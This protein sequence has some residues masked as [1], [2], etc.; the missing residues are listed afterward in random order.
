MAENKTIKVSFA[1]EPKGLQDARN[2]IRALTSDIKQL[3]EQM[4]RAG[5]GFGGL[6]GGVS[7]KTGSI[8]PQKE[9]IRLPNVGSALAG[10]ITKDAQALGQVSRAGTQAIDSLTR[11][12]KSNFSGQIQDIERLKRELSSL[13]KAYAKIQG[14]AG[15]G[16][17]PSVQS[18]ARSAMVSKE[19]QMT[20][21]QAQ[22][23]GHMAAREG[24]NAHFD[25]ARRW[26]SGAA[27]GP[28]AQTEAANARAAAGGGS[29][30]GR[31]FFGGVMQGTGLGG[32]GALLGFAGPAAAG[33]AVAALAKQGIEAYATRHT[34]NAANAVSIGMEPGRLGARIGSSL[35]G[36]GMSIR[37]GSLSTSVAYDAM[38]SQLGSRNDFA[39]ARERMYQDE[40]NMTG[41]GVVTG[42]VSNTLAD[43]AQFVANG[44]SAKGGFDKDARQLALQ[45]SRRGQVAEI[46][47]EQAEMIRNRVASNPLESFFYDQVYNNASSHRSWANAGG[48]GMGV[49]RDKSGKAIDTKMGRFETRALRAGFEAG[50]LAGGMGQLG[51]IAGY[52][53]R[54]HGGSF[55]SAQY[56]GF[57]NAGNIIGVGAQFNA[58]NPMSLFNTAQL[59]MGRGGVDATAGSQISGLVANLMQSGN[60]SGSSGEALMMGMLSAAHTNTTGGDMLAARRLAGGIG[61]YGNLL[62]GKTDNL[63]SGINML[64]ANASGAGGW[65]AKKALM[66]MGVGE[67]TSALRTGKVS[68]L[69]ADQGISIDMVRRYKDFQDSHAFSR[70]MSGEGAGTAVG[71]SVAKARA[72]GGINAYL[73]TVDPKNR[74]QEIWR[75]ASALSATNGGSVDDQIGAITAGMASDSVLA[76]DLKGKGAWKPGMKGTTEGDVFENRAKAAAEQAKWEASKYD[77]IRTSISHMDANQQE[78]ATITAG[79][80]GNSK[81]FSEAVQNMTEAMIEAIAIIAPAKAAEMKKQADAFHAE[82]KK[83]AVAKMTAPFD[84]INKSINAAAVKAVHASGGYKSETYTD[85]E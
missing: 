30:G 63:Q 36:L 28:L 31:G 8:N 60:F 39:S 34:S 68:G 7:G 71:S 58:G 20:S 33:V 32:L 82:Q 85:T 41:L 3:V 21:V 55:L 47:E 38:R 81:H 6:L 80:V 72:A 5:S 12:L 43:G 69:L 50:E 4:G 49:I 15:V 54:K 67:M 65:Y 13:E 76:P 62:A 37:G 23:A 57:G 17:S 44:F 24:G 11:S 35:G 84:E 78:L 22:I 10:S 26:A 73:R 70:Y 48:I 27:I 1:V 64:A 53:L 79:L 2:A 19:L 46:T 9:A 61:V 45:R 52:G 56:G 16:H 29:G 25:E 66:G 75:L 51:G 74:K 42:A 77:D 59:G 40:A 18:A 14:Y 83:K